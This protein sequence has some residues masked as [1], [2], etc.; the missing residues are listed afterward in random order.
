MKICPYC[1]KEYS[2]DFAQ[3]IIDGEPLSEV[4]PLPQPAVEQ[5]ATANEKAGFLTFPDYRWSARDAWKCLGMML[6]FGVIFGFARFELIFNLPGLRNW[7]AKGLG[8]F[9]ESILHYGVELLIVV[10]FAR[11]ETLTTFWSGF[12]LNRK[13][14]QNAWF[15]VATALIIRFFGHFMYI[16]GWGKGVPDHAIHAFKNTAGSER[17]F[18]LAPLIFLA[19]LFEETVYRGFLYKAFRGSYRMITSMALIVAWTAHTHWPQYSHSMLAA[20]DL[21]AIS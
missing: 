5:T 1:G 10:Y 3:C 6:I 18:F 17:Y 11:T 14:T 4:S 7:L 21:E 9:S 13:P 19:P 2:D 20:F 16:H 8:F 15:G 12:G